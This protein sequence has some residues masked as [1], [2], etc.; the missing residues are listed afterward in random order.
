MV[1]FYRRPLSEIFRPFFEN[2]FLCEK[3]SEGIVT[4]ELSQKFPKTAENLRTN[5]MF[6]FVAFR[7]PV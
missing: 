5:P 3:I 6:L 4:E 1:N 7:T 2:S